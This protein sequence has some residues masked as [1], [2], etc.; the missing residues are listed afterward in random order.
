MIIP[1]PLSICIFPVVNAFPASPRLD[2]ILIE[3][4]AKV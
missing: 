2:F 1:D 4:G 3:S